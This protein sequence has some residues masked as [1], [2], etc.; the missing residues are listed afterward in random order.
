MRRRAIFVVMALTTWVAGSALGAMG[1]SVAATAQGSGIVVGK[2]HAGFTPSLTGTKPIV[3]LMVGSGARPGED[4]EHSLADSLHLV[5]INP[6]KHHAT[7]VGIPAR[8]LRAH[9]EPRHQQDQQ[10]AVLRRTGVCWSTRSRTCRASR[11]TTGR[12]PR[13]GV[14]R[15]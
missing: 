11:S 6:A 14:S 1:G 4:V 12:S 2:A 13:S 7:L 8:L 10:L 3:L 9:P 5:F 15:T